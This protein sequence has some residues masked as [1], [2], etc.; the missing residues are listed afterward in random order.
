MKG[1]GI[2]IIVILLVVAAAAAA[3][4][5]L[6]RKNGNDDNGGTVPS[7]GSAGLTGA[8]LGTNFPITVGSCTAYSYFIVK[9][10]GNDKYIDFL[11][12]D[13]VRLVQRYINGKFAENLKVDGLIGSKTLTAINSHCSN[14]AEAVVALNVIRNATPNFS[15]VQRET[16]S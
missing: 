8:L 11:N 12:R 9:I 1:K 16:L 15:Y 10:A 13:N 5:A 6:R 14:W 7:N 3:Y 4:F 2:I